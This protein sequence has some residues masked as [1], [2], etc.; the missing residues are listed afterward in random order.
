[1]DPREERFLKE[2]F[3]DPVLIDTVLWI[4]SRLPEI[5]SWE[6]I[7]E[8]FGP[9]DF[10]G[11]AF[12]GEV[13]GVT[14]HLDEHGVPLKHPYVEQYGYRFN[15]FSACFVLRDDG[16]I[17]FT[18]AIPEEI[19]SSELSLS[20]K[21]PIPPSI[22]IPRSKGVVARFFRK[23]RILVRLYWTRERNPNRKRWMRFTWAEMRSIL[24]NP[25]TYK[26][27]RDIKE[28]SKRGWTRRQIAHA[29]NVDLPTITARLKR[30]AM[31]EYGRLK[32]T[33]EIAKLNAGCEQGLSGDSHFDYGDGSSPT[34]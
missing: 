30:N 8:V 18:L 28:F 7:P 16:T 25:L 12:I 21:E 27:Q 34:Q 15:G 29:L 9:P 1:M 33:A 26:E 5:V 4:R 10:K 14:S 3:K 22:V 6:R 31:F 32:A 19:R 13:P 24:N 11:P 17:G 23:C 20:T 2:V